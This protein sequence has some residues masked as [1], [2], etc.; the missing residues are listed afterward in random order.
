MGGRVFLVEGTTT[1]N[2]PSIDLVNL[3]SKFAAEV[4][5]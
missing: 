3:G 2:L 5:C 1:V 4:G